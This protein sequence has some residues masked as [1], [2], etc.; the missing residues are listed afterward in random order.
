MGSDKARLTLAGISTLERIVMAHQAV[1]CGLIVVV[2]GQH[3]RS[4]RSLKVPLKQVHNPAPEAGMFSSV[5]A[6]VAALDDAVEAFFVHPVDVPLVSTKTLQLLLSQLAAH[7]DCAAAIPCFKGRRGHPPLLRVS[8][9]KQILAAAG[10]HGL[11]GVLSQHQLLHVE[12]DDEAV[13]LDMD[14]PKE[15]AALQALAEEKSA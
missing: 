8:L 9:R 5:Q 15:Y 10:E 3:D 6:G 14:T 13:T 11:R 7:P 1:G 2:T 4:V 12:S